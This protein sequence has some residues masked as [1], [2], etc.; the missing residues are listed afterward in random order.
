MVRLVLNAGKAQGVRPGDV[1]GTIAFHA[2]IPGSTLGAILIEGQ[3]TYVDV[4]EKFV[5][6]VLDK[7]GRYQIH[8]QPVTVELLN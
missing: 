5:N 2:D 8:R 6:Q 4:P 7:T 1:V 3:N